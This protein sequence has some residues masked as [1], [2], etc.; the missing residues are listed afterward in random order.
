MPGDILL[1]TEE[2]SFASPGGPLTSFFGHRAARDAYGIPARRYTRRRVSRF[3]SEVQCQRGIPWRRDPRFHYRR[4]PL[5]RAGLENLLAAREVEVVASSG[6]IEGLAENAGRCRARCCTRLIRAV[7][8]SRRRWNPLW[9][10]VGVGPERGHAGRWG[11][12]RGVRGSAARRYS[13]GASRRYLSRATR[14]RV[15]GGRR[16]IAGAAS[17]ACE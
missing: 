12:A 6:S 8:R 1:G 16:R 9:L 7:R 15:T 5:A 11:D 10:G 2:K 14:R 3:K 4:F 13:R 17:I